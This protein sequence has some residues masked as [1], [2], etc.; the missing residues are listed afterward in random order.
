MTRDYYAVLGVLRD[1]SQEQIKAARRI[2]LREAHPDANPGDPTAV[3]RF[4][5]VYK[6]GEILG[7]PERRRMYDDSLREDTTAFGG[8]VQCRTCHGTGRLPDPCFRCDGKGWRSATPPSRERGQTCYEVLGVAQDASAAQIT[9]AYRNIVRVEGK[10]IPER[11]KSAFSRIGDPRRRAGYDRGLGMTTNGRAGEIDVHVS[12]RVARQGAA[13]HD[14]T[15][16][17]RDLCPHCEGVGRI[18]LPCHNCEGRGYWRWGGSATK[19]DACSGRGTDERACFNCSFSGWVDVTRT[20]TGPIPAGSTEN[21]R[22]T[23]RDDLLG[24][25]TLRLAL[26]PDFARSSE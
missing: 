10:P 22:I 24:V 12:R 20:L 18:M 9:E 13:S 11:V 26:V 7:H 21:S 25:V 8:R 15:V 17:D 4:H 23:V 14:F 5:L 1:A 3:E 16:P 6:A 19:C 2:R